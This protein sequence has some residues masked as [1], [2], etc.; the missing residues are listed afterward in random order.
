MRATAPLLVLVA[1]FL[2]AGCTADATARWTYPPAEPGTAA[3]AAA[4]SASPSQ[5]ATA[6]IGTIDVKAFD[7]GFTPNQLTVDKAGRYAV[8]L[9]NTGQVPHDIT[10]PTGETAQAPA[11][12]SATVEVDVPEGGITFLCSIPGHAQ[13]GMQGSISVAGA[14]AAAS[15]SAS[16]QRGLPRRSAPDQR[17]R[18]RPERARPGH[19]RRDGTAAARR[20]R[21]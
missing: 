15:P 20:R 3:V 17:R 21:P 14:V 6:P 9:T 11:G 18:G 12:G 10:F 4:P 16:T 1:I 2:T 13:A 19:L 5:A 8:T 7:L